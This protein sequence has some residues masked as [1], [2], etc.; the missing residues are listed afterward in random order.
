M[1]SSLKSNELLELEKAY[2]IFE[3]AL[4]KTSNKKDEPKIKTFYLFYKNLEYKLM[5]KEKKMMNN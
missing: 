3:K 4:I 2:I 1:E 5:E